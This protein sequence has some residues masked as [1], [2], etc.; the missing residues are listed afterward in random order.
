[1]SRRKPLKQQMQIADTELAQARRFGDQTSVDMAAAKVEKLN[2]QLLAITARLAEQGTIG[3]FSAGVTTKSAEV[4]QRRKRSAVATDGVVQ[5]PLVGAEK[6]A[7]PN[8]LLRG[9]VFA[10][11]KK[12]QRATL[13]REKVASQG[14]YEVLFSGIQL[15][16]ADLDVWLHCLHLSRDCLGEHVEV[17][18]LPFLRGIGRTEG[19][20]SQ[21]WLRDS[22]V[23]LG[24][25]VIQVKHEGVTVMVAD[26]MVVYEER[27]QVS[28]STISLRVSPTMARLF[29]VAR[30]T[31]ID[32]NVRTKLVGRPLAQWLHAFLATHAKPIALPVST[33][34]ELSGSRTAE[35]R[36]FR[37]TLRQAIVHLVNAG[38]LA[39]WKITED[40][41]LQVLRA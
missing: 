19:A 11:L 4:L 41:R 6:R 21:E 24:M 32:S 14:G 5:L 10:V 2:T 12:G 38:F 17:G 36:L 1:M 40:D 15:D 28:K 31:S 18:L 30:W 34:R 13:M 33:L 26:R 23:R 22:L 3:Q 9:A 37:R 7:S 25:A 39:S 16:Q 20:A 35:L 29:G 8:C 27:E